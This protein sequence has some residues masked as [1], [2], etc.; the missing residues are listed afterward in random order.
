MQ[1]NEIGKFAR[2]NEFPRQ[3]ARRTL[4]ARELDVLIYV[5]RNRHNEEV[6][7]YTDPQKAQSIADELQSTTLQQFSV[8]EL[9]GAG[10]NEIVSDRQI[11]NQ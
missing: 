7:A 11:F 8:E 2:V 4:R 6:A 1:T 10:G 5:V 9:S 3:N